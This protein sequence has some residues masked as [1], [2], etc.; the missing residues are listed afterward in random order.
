MEADHE[1]ED[2][3]LCDEASRREG[4]QE[5]CLKVTFGSQRAA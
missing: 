1:D 2:P 3:S 4:R 5:A